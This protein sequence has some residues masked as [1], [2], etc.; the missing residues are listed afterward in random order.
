M[1]TKQV[2]SSTGFR[3]VGGAPWALP[4]GP[5]LTSKSLD[6]LIVPGQ[7]HFSR[8]RHATHQDRGD[9]V[10]LGGARSIARRIASHG[11]GH[12]GMPRG[13]CS[14]QTSLPYTRC[15]PASDNVL[16]C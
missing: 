3:K 13:V 14:G 10:G 7:E 1:A 2:C 16:R 6:T 4:P 12:P 11:S 9:Q 8:E 15:T 5:A